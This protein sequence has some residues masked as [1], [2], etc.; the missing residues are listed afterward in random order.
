MT[1]AKKTGILNSFFKK[2]LDFYACQARHPRAGGLAERLP[3]AARRHAGT[4]VGRGAGGGGAAV[5][6][7]VQV[8]PR[9]RQGLQVEMNS[10][11]G[12]GRAH[13]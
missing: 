3:P 2:Y 7:Q 4:R 13:H 9:Q 11:S 6:G 12:P 8:R 1:F 10:G 5:G